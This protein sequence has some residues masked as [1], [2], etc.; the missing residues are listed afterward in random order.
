[1][2]QRVNSEFKEKCYRLSAKKVWSLLGLRLS[3]FP[4]LLFLGLGVVLNL[5]PSLHPTLIQATFAPS[6]DFCIMCLIALPAPFLPSLFHAAR[7]SQVDCS[8]MKIGIHPSHRRPCNCSPSVLEIK[9]K[10]LS[11]QG[12]PASLPPR[13]HLS[14]LFPL[15][16]GF[17]PDSP[18]IPQIHHAILISEQH[19]PSPLPQTHMPTHLGPFQLL[20]SYPIQIPT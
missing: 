12:F 11:L 15:N 17:H 19:V 20:D 18:T 7:C 3:V 14:P 9:T 1:M 5:L 8:E 2:P 6:K 10:P 16:S 4:T 13:P